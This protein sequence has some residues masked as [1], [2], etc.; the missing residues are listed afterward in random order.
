MEALEYCQKICRTTESLQNVEETSAT[1]IIESL[2]QIDKHHVQWALLFHTLFLKLA[3]RENHVQGR[4][5]NTEAV[6]CLN[7]QTK[8]AGN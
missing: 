8:P 1:H 6:L 3:Y 5:T 7:L 2:S 4:A